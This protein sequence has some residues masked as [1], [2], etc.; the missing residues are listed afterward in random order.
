MPRLSNEEMAM[1]RIKELFALA[2]Q[3]KDQALA[4]RSVLLAKKIA[5]KC[6]VRIPL[7]LRRQLCKG[8]YGFLMP[9]KTS[10]T[11]LRQGI[12]TTT[13]LRCG[14]VHRIPTQKR[15]G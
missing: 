4:D 8:C 9:G 5:M 12:V 14:R 10:R 3:A 7:P 15:K 13:C 6:K 1:T 11:R 2:Q